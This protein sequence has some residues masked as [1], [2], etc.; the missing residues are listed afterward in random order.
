[1][2]TKMFNK[3]LF[4][5]MFKQLA[6]MAVLCIGIMV[7]GSISYI[8]NMHDGIAFDYSYTN[9]YIISAPSINFASLFFAAIAPGILS[10]FAFRFLYCRSSSDFYHSIPESRVSLFNS[11]FISVLAWLVAGIVFITLINT[12]FFN[13]LSSDF[14]YI[15]NYGGLIPAFLS[16]FAIGFVAAASFALAASFSGVYLKTIPIGLMALFTPGVY[17]YMIQ[18]FLYENVPYSTELPLFSNFDNLCTGIVFEGFQDG[19]F[20]DFSS[21]DF[22]RAL[23]TWKYILSTLIIGV[24]L[25]AIAL[26]LF[27]NRKSETANTFKSSKKESVFVGTWI[28]ALIT[29]GAYEPITNI[30]F[31]NSS[32]SYYYIVMTHLLSFVVYLFYLY[33]TTVDRKALPKLALGF[34]GVLLAEL[35]F[36]SLTGVIVSSKASFTPNAKD[37]ESVNVQFSNSKYHNIDMNV[38][39]TDEKAIQL[40]TDALSREVTKC[41][42]GTWRDYAYGRGS[43]REMNDF[44]VTFRTSSE[45]KT[46][47]VSIPTEE[48][49]ILMEIIRE[50]TDRVEMSS[51]LPDIDDKNTIVLYAHGRA[52]GYDMFSYEGCAFDTKELYR[53]IKEDI[54]NGAGTDY[55]PWST[56]RENTAYLQISALEDNKVMTYDFYAYEDEFPK[57]NAYLRECFALQQEENY[58]KFAEALNSESVELVVYLF[59]AYED[60]AYNEM[61]YFHFSMNP[62]SLSV[63]DLFEKEL[64]KDLETRVNDFPKTEDE[65]YAEIVAVVG[66][67]RIPFVF[68]MDYKEDLPKVLK[69]HLDIAYQKAIEVKSAADTAA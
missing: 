25:Y 38:E 6:P 61:G 50:N 68:S 30:L 20:Y 42:D 31:V 40:L 34:V 13:L 46:R 54:E 10:I 37:V 24:V 19:L 56:Y 33:I 69:P 4:L 29:L 53:C 35:S 7:L 39:L 8:F 51:P 26:I 59:N 2:K 65:M 22:G 28:G 17:V 67:D 32:E 18:H 52:L 62:G 12:A 66:N 49:E 44:E 23:M 55:Y 27:R 36:L 58:E 21:L 43:G 60:V 47:R 57:T 15:I 64:L 1:M 63:K 11:I 3:R 45:E 16:L 41:Q 14:N 9:E 5:D 48:M